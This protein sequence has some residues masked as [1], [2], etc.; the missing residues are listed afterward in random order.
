MTENPRNHPDPADM[1]AAVAFFHADGHAATQAVASAFAGPEGRLAAMPDILAARIRQPEGGTAWDYYYTTTS[2]EFVGRTPGGNAVAAVQHGVGPMAGAETAARI[3]AD[4][5]GHV[6]QE[7]FREI[8]AGRLGEVTVVDLPQHLGEHE[9]V[10]RTCMTR[11]EALASPLAMARLGPSAEAYLEALENLALR[12]HRLSDRAVAH[13]RILQMSSSGFDALAYGRT[14]RPHA[15]LLSI[16]QIVSLSMS[17]SGDVHLVSDLATHDWTDG[18][19]FVGLRPG[20]R[21]APIRLAPG[22]RSILADPRTREMILVA[23]DPKPVEGLRRI[24]RIGLD[25]GG[26][27]EYAAR[28]AKN[29]RALDGEFEMPVSGVE[30]IGEQ[31]GIRFEP[32]GYH[33]FFRYDV[34]DLAP[35]APAGS[36]AYEL[37]DVDL[38]GSDQ[39]ALI[40]F[41]RVRFDAHRRY[42]SEN[43]VAADASRLMAA[44]SVLAA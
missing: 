37:I 8:L 32:A 28:E 7:M 36:N 34:S 5:G 39:V 15:R 43:V 24:D 12:L 21:E 30:W 4:E 33:G 20:W 31:V 40:R 11:E 25:A 22:Y 13:P 16:G 26:N 42:A 6:A 35:F 38:D 2:A 29:G 9:A 23:A 14:P 17:G 18:T 41:A 3:Y 19:R 10:R 44:M 27:P 1:D